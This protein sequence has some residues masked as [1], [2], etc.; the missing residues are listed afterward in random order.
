MN[1]ARPGVGSPDVPAVGAGEVSSAYAEPVVSGEDVDTSVFDERTRQEAREIAARYPWARSGLLPMLHLVQSVQGYVSQAGI[2]FC[3][4]ELGLT[5]AEVTGVVTYYTMIKR[6]PCGEHLVSVCTNTLCAA[7]GGDEIYRRLSKHLGKRGRPLGNE[8]TAGEPGKPGSV[9]L[10]HVACAAACDL[11]PVVQV[12][13]EFYDK[14]TPESAVGL[15][16]ALRAGERPAPSRGAPL[17]SFREIE[18]Q[19]A[20]FFD[21]LEAE[22]AGPSAAEETLRG[23]RLAEAN[24][25]AEPPM[26]EHAPLPPQEEEEK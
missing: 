1:Q 14:Q 23:A 19:L 24:G 12:N 9:T 21:N 16:K 10:E 7:L 3:A 22:V 20:G 11:A 6:R 2:A 8:E 4:E 26:P 25:W 17:S 18:R 15:V 5:T 13:Y